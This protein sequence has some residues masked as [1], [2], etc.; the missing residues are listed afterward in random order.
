MPLPAA[1]TGIYKQF[2][3][4]PQG[5]RLEFAEMQ[6]KMFLRSAGRV[7]TLPYGGCCK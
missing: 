1:G 3:A 2:R 6:C 4:N 5:V 7:M